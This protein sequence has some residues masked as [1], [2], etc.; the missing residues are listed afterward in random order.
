MQN[1]WIVF[2]VYFFQFWREMTIFLVRI[3]FVVRTS[4]VL[5]LSRVKS[6][7]KRLTSWSP[8]KSFAIW[9]IF[10][11]EFWRFFVD[12]PTQRGIFDLNLGLGLPF[13][14]WSKVWSSKVVIRAHAASKIEA[15]SVDLK[16]KSIFNF[17]LLFRL[18]YAWFP[19][20]SSG[21]ISTT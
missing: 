15:D 13:I 21:Q 9:L 14:V 6:Y 10:C 19:S 4:I 11:R 16:E 2:R 7:R 20:A 1:V 5:K 17:E 18:F 8:L 12:F 3:R